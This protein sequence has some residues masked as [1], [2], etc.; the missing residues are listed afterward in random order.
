MIFDNKKVIHESL[1]NDMLKPVMLNRL[2]DSLDFTISESSVVE[3]MRFDLSDLGITYVDKGKICISDM[4]YSY[5]YIGINN[6]PIKGKIG[7]E[8]INLYGKDGM[9]VNDSLN[10][11]KIY[12]EYLGHANMNCCEYY[13]KIKFCE[14]N[15]RF[16]IKNLVITV[17]GTIGDEPFIGTYTYSGSIV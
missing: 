1:K 16:E 11:Y 9:I 10:G 6:N 2:L 8:D 14:T 5:D 12:T 13:N 4:W 3:N 15:I 17:Q 7:C